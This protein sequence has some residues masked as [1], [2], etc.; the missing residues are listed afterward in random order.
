MVVRA[1]CAGVRR[2]AVWGGT[3]VH[4][5]GH[6][7]VC[8]C[9]GLPGP[10]EKVDVEVVASWEGWGKLVHA[11]EPASCEGWGMRGAMPCGLGCASWRDHE[12][13]GA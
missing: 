8:V 12:R 4:D 13:W 5:I 6:V 9:V 7:C 2:Y 1:C 3:V 10:H 11:F